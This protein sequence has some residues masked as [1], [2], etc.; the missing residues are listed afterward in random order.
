MRAVL[1]LVSIA[2]GLI[3]VGVSHAQVS[4]PGVTHLDAQRVVISVFPDSLDGV[5]VDA[6]ILHKKDWVAYS[7]RF[8]PEAVSEWVGEAKASLAGTSASNSPVQSRVLA[9]LGGNRG[10]VLARTVRKGKHES[11]WL[12]HRLE[13]DEPLLIK[14]D[15]RFTDT[16]LTSLREAARLS[17][18]DSGAFDSGLVAPLVERPDSL[19]PWPIDIPTPRYP[20]RLSAAGIDGLVQVRYVIDADGRAAMDTFDVLWASAS[21]FIPPVREALSRGRFRPARMGGKPVRARVYQNIR[22]RVHGQRAY[23]N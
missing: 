5:H 16:L 18:I 23:W 10:I 14:A 21:E 4:R 6:K 20:N 9:G 7:A 17:A 11:Y 1:V 13:H 8:R 15:S 22:F 2:S 3:T 12:L 19:N